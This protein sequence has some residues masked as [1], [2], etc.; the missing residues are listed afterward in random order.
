MKLF[1]PTIVAAAALAGSAQAGNVRI[2]HLSPDAPA[3]DVLVDGNVAFAGVAFNE[4]TGYANLPQ[5]NYLVQVVPAGASKPVVIETLLAVPAT[6][7]FTAAAINPLSSITATVFEDDN[8]RSPG[9]TRVRFVHAS[10]GTP[11]VDIALADGGPVLFSNVSYGESGGYIQVPA[12]TYDLEARVA[13]TETVALSL[14]GTSLTGGTSIT[15]WASGLLKGSPAL[16]AAVSLDVAPLSKVRILH[17]SPDAPAVDIKVNGLTAIE[18]LGYLENTAYVDLETGSTNIQVVPNGLEAP[19]VIDATLDLEA[20][21]YSVL[22]IGELA[23]ITALPLA[24]DNMLSDGARIRFVHASPDAPNVDIALADGGPV[25]FADVAF[26]TSGGYIEVPGGIYDLEAR[27][28]GTD[29]VALSVPG[30]NVTGNRVF[31]VVATGLL[32]G[33]PSLSALPLLDAEAC[34]TDVNGDA[35][36]SI[37]DVLAVLSA[38]S[39]SDPWADLNGSGTVEVMDLMAVIQSF[40]VCRSE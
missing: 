17:A 34:R 8:Q 13:G 6:G 18:N 25:L 38:W 30:V 27:V 33:S 32:S 4:V 39:T 19:V 14:P 1:I 3:V 23:D 7:D 10:P 11:S 22:A 28:A 24:D 26:G 5:G 21:D 40:G 12:G 16:G 36:T 31:T 29:T 2:A 35:R 15:V 37:D 20:A 9:N